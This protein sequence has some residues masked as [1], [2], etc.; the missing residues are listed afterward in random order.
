[1]D[2]VEEKNRNESET[3]NK[4]KAMYKSEVISLS[5]IVSKIG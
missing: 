5:L 4:S 3:V 1:V 2:V